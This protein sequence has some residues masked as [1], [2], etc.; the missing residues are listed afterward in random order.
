M[1]E[2]KLKK[3]I[4][5][6]VIGLVTLLYVCSGLGRYRDKMLEVIVSILGVALFIYLMYSW[7]TMGNKKKVSKQPRC[8]YVLGGDYAGYNVYEGSENFI[9]VSGDNGSISEN[10][11]QGISLLTEINS[12]TVEKCEDVAER[13]EEAS[14]E[15]ILT[16]AMLMGPIGALGVKGAGES[17]TH[18]IAVFFKNG[19]RSLIRLTSESAYQNLKTILYRF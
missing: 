4:I 10:S 12:T 2:K 6:A 5:W 9:I 14:T 11:V 15:A 19:K 1:D 7:F 17:H 8:G 18:D 3:I 13:H 16:G